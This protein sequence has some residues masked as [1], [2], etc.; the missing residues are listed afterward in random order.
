M[1]MEAIWHSLQVIDSRLQK[2]AENQ[3]YGSSNM[4]GF[5]NAAHEI[6]D[7]TC[8]QSSGEVSST[9]TMPMEA[10]VAISRLPDQNLLQ[11]HHTKPDCESQA[12]LKPHG[13]SAEESNTR[14]SLVECL[15]TSFDS[16]EE[17][18]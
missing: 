7:A 10:A 15:S 11:A 12:K 3:I 1:V 2:S 9:G 14:V 13:S 17:Y 16:D 8:L 6:D 18:T 4:I 5:G